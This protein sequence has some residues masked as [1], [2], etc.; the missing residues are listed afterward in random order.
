MKKPDAQRLIEFQKLLLAFSHV[1]RHLKRRHLDT[2]LHENDTE[3]SYNLAMTAWFLCEYFPELNQHEVIKLALVHDIVEVHAGDTYIYA[4][5]EVIA[6]KQSREKAALAQLHKDWQDF[7]DMVNH[8]E[9]YEYRSTPEAKFVYALDK[10]MPMMLIYI[11][12]GKTWHEE[13]ITVDQLHTSKENKVALSPEIAPYYY[14]IREI[15]LKSPH[16]IAPK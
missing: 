15:L 10:L 13:G 5:P 3:H 16:L 14:E 4:S 12:D 9:N 7:P 2:Y 6:T 1:E 8:I 11:N